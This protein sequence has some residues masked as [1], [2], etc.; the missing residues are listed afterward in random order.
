MTYKREFGEWDWIEVRS[1][2]GCPFA[3]YTV[4]GY[5]IA[6]KIR[7]EMPPFC[8]F[9]EAVEIIKLLPSQ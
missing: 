8:S 1:E 4:A 9:D 5:G 3:L 6:R 7:N 2:P